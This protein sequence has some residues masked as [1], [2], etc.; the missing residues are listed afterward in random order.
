MAT[1]PKGRAWPRGQEARIYLRLPVWSAM[2]AQRLAHL[3]NINIASATRML[4]GA[5]VSD[6]TVARAL[7]LR[8][9][10]LFGDLFEIRLDDPDLIGVRSP[11]FY[12]LSYVDA[13]ADGMQPSEETDFA[14]G[15]SGLHVTIYRGQEPVMTHTPDGTIYIHPGGRSDVG[16]HEVIRRRFGLEPADY[17]VSGVFAEISVARTKMAKEGMS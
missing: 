15:V 10:K 14:L 2:G 9:D 17:P 11:T 8:N 6:K 7:I 1:T 16:L 3:L 4:G 12:P 13:V 5:P